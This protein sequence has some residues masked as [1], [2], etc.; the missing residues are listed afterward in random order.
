MDMTHFLHGNFASAHLTA[1]YVHALTAPSLIKVLVFLSVITETLQLV[2]RLSFDLFTSP[3][4]T[5]DFPR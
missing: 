1:L 4:I 3:D 2:W 5:S